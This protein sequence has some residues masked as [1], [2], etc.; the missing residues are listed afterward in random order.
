[1]AL[2]SRD[3]VINE[4]LA[5]PSVNVTSPV[6]QATPFDNRAVTIAEPTVTTPPSVKVSDEEAMIA[7]GIAMFGATLGRNGCA[8]KAA[9]YAA[10]LLP[11]VKGKEMIIM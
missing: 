9:C 7:T 6:R 1:M 4:N 3:N 8:Q 5:V 10:T 11:P 2:Q